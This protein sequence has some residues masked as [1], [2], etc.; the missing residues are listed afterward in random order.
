ME[1]LMRRQ[2]PDKGLKLIGD[3]TT[4][5]SGAK[6]YLVMLKY[7]CNPADPEATALLQEMSGVPSPPC[8]RWKNSNLRRLCYLVKQDLDNIAWWY[9][10]DDG[11]DDDILLLPVQNPHI[12]S[13]AA[14]CRHYG[15]DTKEIIHYCSAECR[16]CHE[17]DLWTRNFRPTVEYAVSRMNIGM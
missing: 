14:G 7:C 15:P 9:W 17:F 4:E 16:I 1:R 12:C 10:L 11:N 3:A 2:N 6:Y 5:D 13:W 8:S